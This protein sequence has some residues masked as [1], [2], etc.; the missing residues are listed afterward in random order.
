MKKLAAYLYLF[1]ITIPAFLY[2]L[3]RV[4]YLYPDLQK[5]ITNYGLHLLGTFAWTLSLGAILVTMI[6]KRKYI[7]L[8]CLVFVAIFLT[9][10]NELLQYFEPGR[11]VDKYDVLAQAVGCVVTYLCIIVIGP[12]A[13]LTE[14]LDN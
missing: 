1:L 10:L 5:F 7:A 9:T 11:V 12:I 14:D 8:A 6:D 3:W 13:E 2:I 4:D